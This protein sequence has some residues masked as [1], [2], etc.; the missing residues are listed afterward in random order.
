MVKTLL[1]SYFKD[2]LFTL[3]VKVTQTSAD[4]LWKH[5]CD[6]F[7]GYDDKAY[8]LYKKVEQELENMRRENPYDRY[9]IRSWREGKVR[10]QYKYAGELYSLY[11]IERA[12]SLTN[13]RM[14]FK[15]CCR[16]KELNW[17]EDETKEEQIRNI[18]TQIHRAEYFFKMPSEVQELDEMLFLQ[19]KQQ[20]KIEDAEWLQEQERI[21]KLKSMHNEHRTPEQWRKCYEECCKAMRNGTDPDFFTSTG[22]SPD[23]QTIPAHLLPQPDCELCMKEEQKRKEQEEAIAEY[24][25]QLEQNRLDY[26]RQR[27]EEEAKYEA[28][29]EERR[30]RMKPLETL[31]CECCNVSVKGQAMFNAHLASKQHKQAS[32]YCKLCDHTSRCANEHKAHLESKKHILRTQTPDGSLPPKVYTCEACEYSTPYLSAYRNHQKSK[33]HMDKCSS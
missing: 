11:D 23:F 30:K 5:L 22:I 12:L 26:E 4:D 21:R 13:L 18:E 10:P 17:L 19:A 6:S 16:D 3:D 33:K 8:H 1:P 27:A 25:R 15:F 14:D 7:E 24:Q 31:T 28:E 2:K 29:Q 9:S 20:W 32:L